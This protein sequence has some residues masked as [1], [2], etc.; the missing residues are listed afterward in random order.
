[1]KKM[2]G[3]MFTVYVLNDVVLKFPNDRPREWVENTI[4][5]HKDLSH[6]GTI[7]PIEVVRHDRQIVIVQKK[8]PGIRLKDLDPEEVEQNFQSLFDFKIY[9]TEQCNNVGYEPANLSLGNIFM[10]TTSPK[11]HIVDVH[12][13]K[14]L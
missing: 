13:F 12:S 6:I 8:A 11:F 3:E 2:I 1:M 10:N 7:L 14:K 9:I 4:Q 5:I